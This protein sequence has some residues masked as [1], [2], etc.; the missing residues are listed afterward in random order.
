MIGKRIDSG[1]TLKREPIW[2]GLFCAS[3]HLV[4]IL[5]VPLL[6]KSDIVSHSLK[7][8]NKFH[9]LLRLYLGGN[10]SVA[11]F[12][13]P[14]VDEVRSHAVLLTTSQLVHT[15]GLQCRERQLQ[16]VKRYSIYLSN[17][18]ISSFNEYHYFYDYVSNIV[19]IY[20]LF[21][22]LFIIILFIP[23]WSYARLSSRLW[24]PTSCPPP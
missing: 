1:G 5:P 7:H 19:T 11:V 3:S 15:K 16:A 21:S 24:L 2:V 13:S 14:K 23:L 12:L 20:Y 8:P 6:Q 22:F 9:Q 4:V 10:W 18:A 17:V